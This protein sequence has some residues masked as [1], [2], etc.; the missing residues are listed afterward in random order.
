[1]GHFL[2]TDKLMSLLNTGCAESVETAEPDSP[3]YPLLMELDLLES[4]L[5]G[6]IGRRAVRGR[7]EL[8]L[9]REQIRHVDDELRKLPPEGVSTGTRRY[10]QEVLR[11]A[12]L[13]ERG[14]AMKEGG[15]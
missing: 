10:V 15:S 9:L 13:L 6:L 14:V 2:V 3:V 11:H 5:T 12:R 7:Q 1:M 4:H 8:S